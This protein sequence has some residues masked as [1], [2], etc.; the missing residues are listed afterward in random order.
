MIWEENP[1]FSETSISSW[2]FFTNPCEKYY[3]SQIG[4]LPQFSGWKFQKMF[5]RT[6]QFCWL[7][8]DSLGA[9]LWERVD[10]LL[11][12]WYFAA[13]FEIPTLSVEVLFIPSFTK[14]EEVLHKTL[15]FS[16]PKL[17]QYS[18][19]EWSHQNCSLRSFQTGF[20]WVSN[21]QI[22]RFWLQ[23]ICVD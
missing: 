19:H 15:G 23:S 7:F 17:A 1:L 18:N 21:S 10:V 13:L 12:W 14:F 16:T 9:S 4:S 22:Q 2:W 20:C 8:S 6:I 3:S 5:E 11:K